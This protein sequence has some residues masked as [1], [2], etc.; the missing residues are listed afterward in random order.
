MFKAGGKVRAQL[1]A[2]A[3]PV[4]EGNCSKIFVSAGYSD[5]SEEG[6]SSNLPEGFTDR[7][8]AHFVA[9]CLGLP[10]PGTVASSSTTAPGAGGSASTEPTRTSA[11]TGR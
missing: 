10:K 1:L 7:R 3:Q 4:D 6:S 8:K 9:G 2:Q 11:A 5:Y